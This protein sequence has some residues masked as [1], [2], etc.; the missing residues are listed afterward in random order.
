MKSRI[1]DII[2]SMT[3]LEKGW[4]FTFL[5]LSFFPILPNAVRSICMILLFVLSLRSNNGLIKHKIL[6]LISAPFII[7]LF[8]GLLYP[9]INRALNFFVLLLP[10]IA[11]PFSYIRLE[12]AKLSMILRLS[13]LFFVLAILF[14]ILIEAFFLMTHYDLLAEATNRTQYSIKLRKLIEQPFDSHPTYQGYF[15]LLSLIILAMEFEK[16]KQKLLRLIIAII[17]VLLVC[18]L[19]I[20]TSR[21]ALISVTVFCLILLFKIKNYK[22]KRTILAC[23]LIIGMLLTGFLSKPLKTRLVDFKFDNLQIPDDS[24]SSSN[25]SI[26]TRIAIWNCDVQIIR[27]NPMGIGIAHEKEALNNCVNAYNVSFLKDKFYNSHNQYLSYFICG[28]FIGFSAFLIFLLLLMRMARET[29][30]WALLTFVLITGIFM[31]TENILYRNDGLLAY[32]IMLCNIVFISKPAI[33]SKKMDTN[34]ELK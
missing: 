3:I 33:L 29:K 11:I 19:F 34:T 18:F 24:I 28:G 26:S 12:K 17:S 13:G 9:S 21:I 15:I 25:N 23:L 22:T 10:L 32:S 7:Y 5:L 4:S 31:L 27:N 1:I 16:I 30:S 8:T 6:I 20:I 2:N 14:M